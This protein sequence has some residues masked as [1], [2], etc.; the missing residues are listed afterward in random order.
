MDVLATVEVNHDISHTPFY[1]VLI[2]TLFISCQN[3]SLAKN[4]TLG[5]KQN[6][7]ISNLDLETNWGSNENA[8]CP[9]FKFQNQ[10]VWAEIL[11][12]PSNSSL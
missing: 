7:K 9:V 10:L 6:K 2:Y 8:S 3:S 11:K 1:F 4:Q 5:N 12:A